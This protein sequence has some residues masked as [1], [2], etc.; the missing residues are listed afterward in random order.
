MR[1]G[2]EDKDEEDEAKVRKKALIYSLNKQN[3]QQT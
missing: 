1:G 3:E 2:L